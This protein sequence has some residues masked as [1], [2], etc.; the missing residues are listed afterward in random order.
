MA[1]PFIFINT[2]D[3]EPGAIEA[4][5]ERFRRTAQVVQAEEPR[6]LY[7]AC[8]IDEETNRAATVQVH[9]DA[10]NMAY[11]MK[12]VAQHIDS[13]REVLDFSTMSIQIFG[14]PT[15]AI[16]EHIREL[17]GAGVD[18]RVAPAA[19]AFDRFPEAM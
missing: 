13:A 8:H 12:L 15:E 18:V 17:S 14:S 9:A 3:V 1:E 10:D 11:H 2:Y 7:F 4:Y 5:K 6:M 19:V 16:L